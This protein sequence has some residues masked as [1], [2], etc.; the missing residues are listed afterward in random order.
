MTKEEISQAINKFLRYLHANGVD[1]NTCIVT[2]NI[3]GGGK[4]VHAHGNII[5]YKYALLAILAD[6]Q[7]YTLVLK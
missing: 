3:P 2:V 1:T 7:G 4:G 6:E 5:D